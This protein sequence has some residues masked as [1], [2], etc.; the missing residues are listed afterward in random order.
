[1]GGEQSLS[2]KDT[3]QAL[4]TKRSTFARAKSGNR[5]RNER[6]CFAKIRYHVATCDSKD[7]QGRKC[8]CE[9]GKL[10]TLKMQYSLGIRQNMT[11]D[12]QQFCRGMFLAQQAR[13]F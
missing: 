11:T 2:E 1:M 10:V 8:G 4:I 3:T 7:M 6:G 9:S 12:D 13:S 5:D